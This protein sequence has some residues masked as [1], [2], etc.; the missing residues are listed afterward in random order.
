MTSAVWRSVLLRHLPQVIA[1]GGA[2][3]ALAQVRHVAG[4]YRRTFIAP[5]AAD[6]TDHIRH[7]LVLVR[8]TPRKVCGSMRVS[9]PAINKPLI[10]PKLKRR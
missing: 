2:H 9:P 5:A 4:F 6:E 10:K 1:R 7:F 3:I 8:L